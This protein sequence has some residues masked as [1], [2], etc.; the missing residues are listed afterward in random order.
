MKKGWFAAMTAVLC[1]G[2]A[3]TALA[4]ESDGA[5]VTYEVTAINELDVSGNPGNMTVTTA[6]A[7]EQPDAVTDSSTTYAIT[8]NGTNKKITAVLDGDM[9]DETT[10]SV[11][12]TAPNGGTS[13]GQVTL[14]SAAADVVTGITEVAENGKNITYELDA[15]VGAGIVGSASK[16]V[17]FTIADG[18]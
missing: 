4:D 6:T 7:G 17:T 1:I 8:T 14:S 13:A 2:L 16:T 12:L 3:G 18:N 11:T 15:E 9:P 10:L 5:S